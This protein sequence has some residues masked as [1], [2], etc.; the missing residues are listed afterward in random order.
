MA[1]EIASSSPSKGLSDATG[2]K[3]SPTV[4]PHLVIDAGENRR[5]NKVTIRKLGDQALLSILTVLPSSR[6]LLSSVLR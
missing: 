4:D 3:I 6:H 2:P 1:I 5:L